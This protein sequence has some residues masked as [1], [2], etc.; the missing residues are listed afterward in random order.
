MRAVCALFLLGI[1]VNCGGPAKPV[2]APD[3]VVAKHAHRTT[4]PTQVTLYTVVN[5]RNGTG[6]HSALL[7]DAG[8]R[9]LFDPAGSYASPQTPERHDVLFGMTDRAVR[10]Y[11][12]VSYTHLTL[13]TTSRV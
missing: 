10:A 3:A 1:L 5:T 7:I 11:I 13:P 4:G 9:V 12:T 6:A 8:E 2:W